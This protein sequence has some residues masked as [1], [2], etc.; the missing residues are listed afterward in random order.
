[1][2]DVLALVF[3][4]SSDVLALL[5]EVSSDAS[6]AADA[7]SAEAVLVSLMSVLLLLRRTRQKSIVSSGLSTLTRTCAKYVAW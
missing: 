2:P 1:M 3:E 5:F 6:Y 4:V 7:A